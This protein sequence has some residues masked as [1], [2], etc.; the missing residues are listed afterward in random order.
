MRG[1]EDGIGLKDYYGMRA[2]VGATNMPFREY[3]FV[4]VKT[5]SLAVAARYGASDQHHV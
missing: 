5:G 1:S 2:W 4:C 3:G